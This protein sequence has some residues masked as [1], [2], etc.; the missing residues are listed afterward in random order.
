MISSAS[1]SFSDKFSERTVLSGSSLSPVA[2]R[3]ALVGA[4][5]AG[6]VAWRGEARRKSGG[7]LKLAAERSS[8]SLRSSR[9]SRH[10]RV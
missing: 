8:G 3:D 7:I 10:S 1:Y 4:K 5:E 6:W 9:L 2:V